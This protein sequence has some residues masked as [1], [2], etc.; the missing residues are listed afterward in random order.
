MTKRLP[1][2]YYYK[3]LNFDLVGAVEPT[4]LTRQRVLEAV[5]NGPF[6]AHSLN[7]NAFQDM[8]FGAYELPPGIAS[9]VAMMLL[10][11]DAYEDR[12]D[13]LRG[14]YTENQDTEPEWLSVGTLHSGDYQPSFD[15]GVYVSIGMSDCCILLS[16]L[17]EF[18]ERQ[19]NKERESTKPAPESTRY[20]HSGGNALT[21]AL[22]VY[23]GACNKE[24]KKP[25]YNDA[26]LSLKPETNERIEEMHPVNGVGWRDQ[27]GKMKWLTKQQTRG[28]YNYAKNKY[29]W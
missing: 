12:I 9:E 11:G 1:L 15:R 6:K 14:P 13:K 18:A 24:G 22:H 7:D 19:K 16:H 10:N 26:W 17:N 20:T 25:N 3:D 21:A 27:K 28:R 4:A 8:P 2:C 29:T 5:K 23:L